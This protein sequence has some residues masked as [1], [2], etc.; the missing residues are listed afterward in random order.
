[1]KNRA[2]AMPEYVAKLVRLTLTRMGLEPSE[3]QDDVVVCP[4]TYENGNAL[5]LVVMCVAER[6]WFRE[7]RILVASVVT[8]DEATRATR[9]FSQLNTSVPAGPTDVHFMLSFSARVKA[10]AQSVAMD[11]Q[12]GRLV[13]LSGRPPV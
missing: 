6:G 13:S 10:I 12:T 4:L 11:C 8:L 3:A 5:S 9:V 1:M 7:K 2:L